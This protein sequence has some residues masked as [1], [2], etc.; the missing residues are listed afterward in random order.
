LYYSKQITSTT[1]KYKGSHAAEVGYARFLLEAV[2][3][4]SNA[5]F[6]AELRSG[7]MSITNHLGQKEKFEAFFP[8]SRV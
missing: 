4:W 7:S 6:S 3:Q 1:N 5:G 2:F 8:L